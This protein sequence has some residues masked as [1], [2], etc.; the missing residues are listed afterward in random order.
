M[1]RAQAWVTD[2]MKAMGLV[3]VASEP[4]MDFGVS[5]EKPAVRASGTAPGFA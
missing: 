1:A 3:N 5:W 2:K 4:F